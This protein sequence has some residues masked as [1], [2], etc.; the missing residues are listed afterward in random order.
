M[1]IRAKF[2]GGKADKP[3]AERVMVR[4]MCKC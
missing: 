1:D 4:E 2:D 3:I